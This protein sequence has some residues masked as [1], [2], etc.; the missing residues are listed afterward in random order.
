MARS[1]PRAAGL[2]SAGGL[3]FRIGRGFPIPLGTEKI[4]RARISF[5]NQAYAKFRDGGKDKS[6]Q[7]RSGEF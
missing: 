5:I 2:R 3:G 4:L 1:N 7:E 6:L